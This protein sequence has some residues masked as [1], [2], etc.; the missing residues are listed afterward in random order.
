MGLVG[1][2]KSMEIMPSAIPKDGSFD[3]QLLQMSNDSLWRAVRKL[4]TENALRLVNTLL[5]RPGCTFGELRNLTKFGTNELNHLL[6]EMKPLG[7]IIY[8]GKQY[9]LTLFCVMLVST[10]QQL[11]EKKNE[12]NLYKKYTEEYNKLRNSDSYIY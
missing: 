7:L 12:T 3:V 4:S 6:Y 10:L 5:E 8:E 11:V 2:R 1:I 9:Y